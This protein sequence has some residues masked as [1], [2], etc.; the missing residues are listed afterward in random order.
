MTESMILDLIMGF[1][2]RS[3]R[4]REWHPGQI[5]GAPVETIPIL[6]LPRVDQKHPRSGQGQVA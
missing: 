2:A 3:F 6:A 4:I 5:A 1:M